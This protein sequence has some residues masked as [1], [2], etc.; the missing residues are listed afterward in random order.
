MHRTPPPARR[1]VSPATIH[2][3]SRDQRELPGYGWVVAFFGTPQPTLRFTGEW[4]EED[5]RVC[6]PL[7]R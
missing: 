2:G 1:Q 5:N 6:P 7:V 3:R 4:C